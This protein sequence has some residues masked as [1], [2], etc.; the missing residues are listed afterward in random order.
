M[1]DIEHNDIFVI[2]TNIAN[3][4]SWKRIFVVKEQA[5]YGS[6]ALVGERSEIEIAAMAREH[7]QHILLSPD[8]HYYVPLQWLANVMPS[9]RELLIEMA[10]KARAI[11]NRQPKECEGA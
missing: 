11:A 8:D 4:P 10:I 5:V 9:R 6:P 1:S 3:I 2:D 7:G